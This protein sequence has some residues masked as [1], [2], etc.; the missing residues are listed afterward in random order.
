MLEMLTARIVFAHRCH[1]VHFQMEYLKYLH[2]FDMLLRFRW[3]LIVQ[4]VPDRF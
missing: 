1:P 3:I 2:G 4:F